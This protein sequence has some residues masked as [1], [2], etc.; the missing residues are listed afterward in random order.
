M[1]I[2]G[3]IFPGNQEKE[4]AAMSIGKNISEL[5]KRRKLTQSEL[6]GKLGVT[7]QSVSKWENDVCVPDVSLFPQLAKLFNVS[8]DR[9]RLSPGFL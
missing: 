5:R 1:L 9:L 7:E 3:R 6:A 8:I 4:G 2:T